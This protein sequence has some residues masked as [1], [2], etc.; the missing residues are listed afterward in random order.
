[1]NTTETIFR[2]YQSADKVGRSDRSAGDRARHRVKVK[3][4]LKDGLQDVI[5]EESLIGKSGDKKIKIPIRGL[6]EFRF[7][8]GPNTK[9]TAQGDG[10]THEG[11]VVGKNSDSGTGNG[12]GKG[13]AGDQ[14]GEDVYETE[15]TL[16]ELTTLLFEDLNL[17]NLVRK[18]LKEIQS[19]SYRKKDGF[20][21]KGIE[22]RLDKRKTAINRIKRKIASNK[23]G[24]KQPCL[25]CLDTGYIDSDNGKVTCPDCRVRFHEAD[26]RFKH[27][28]TENRPES[29]AVMFCIMDTSGSMDTAKK[30]LA[31]SLFYILYL[32]LRTKYQQMEVVFISHSTVAEEVD[33]DKFFHT[34]ESGGTFISSGY[35][36]A[37]E[38]IKERYNPSLWNLYVL[39]AS[40]GDNFSSDNDKAVDYINQLLAIC[41]LVGYA[42]I[43]PDGYSYPLSASLA[44]KNLDKKFVISILKDKNDVWPSLKRYLTPEY[45]DTI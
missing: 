17:P 4:S 14:R 45:G 31:R 28:E 9:G 29:N 16:D 7:V 18:N 21:R 24:L 3:Q 39:H 15:I 27:F 43:K 36:K 5:A 2:D 8:F 41:T 10:N 22:V 6:K 34:G 44:N 19:I 32:F 35:E 25:T 11:Q 20:R 30:F 13:Q 1:M 38:I 26:K 42:E 12:P 23:A 37:L 33:E 40:D